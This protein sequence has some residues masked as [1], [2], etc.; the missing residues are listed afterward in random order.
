MSRH[1]T[2][3]ARARRTG[4]PMTHGSQDAF[5]YPVARSGLMTY[6]TSQTPAP[7]AADTQVSPSGRR[8]GWNKVPEVTAYFWVIKVLCTTVGETAADLLNENARPRPDRYVGGDERAA[9]GRPGRAVPA[10]AYV[11]GVYW[12]AVV[13][14]QRRRHADQRQPHRQLRRAAGDQHHRFA[15]T[16]AIVFAVWYRRERTLSIHHIDTTRRE[17]FYWLAVL[18][19]FALGTA[20]GDLVSERSTWATG[21]PRVCSAPCHRRGRPRAL[22]LGLDAVLE[23]LDRLH[24]HPSARRVHRRLP[25]AA[26]RRRRPGPGHRRHQRA[27]PQVILGLVVYLSVTR[28]DVAQPQPSA[29]HAA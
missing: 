24:P 18:F 16:L 23:L 19:T 25:L 14:D 20:A 27:V 26:E 5:R 10:T 13:A 3:G 29:R 7:S 12:L 1:G 8:L 17:S 9:G 11:A 4:R 21:S 15:V 2:H 28:K 22:R 6:E